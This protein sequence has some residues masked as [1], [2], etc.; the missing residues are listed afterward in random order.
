M[1]FE[2]VEFTKVFLFQQFLVVQ[3]QLHTT[4]HNSCIIKMYTI[5]IN[6]LG[7]YT[8]TL[9]LL[10]FRYDFLYDFLDFASLYD[11]SWIN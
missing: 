1:N 7:P 9:L 11:R 4:V 5:I 6:G 2:Q 3:N 8:F 10:I